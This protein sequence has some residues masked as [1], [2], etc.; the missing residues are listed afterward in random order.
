MLIFPMKAKWFVTLLGGIQ[1]V[2]MLNAG[3]AGAGVAYL[4]H[5]GGLASGF[6]FLFVWTRWQQKKW[7]KRSPKNGRNLR[8]V[9]NNERDDEN[10]DGPR[11]WN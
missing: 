6:V 10:S 7:K 11:Y 8:L 9:V 5:L 4:A 2:A 1:I 3:V